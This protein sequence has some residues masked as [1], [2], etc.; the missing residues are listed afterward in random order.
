MNKLRNMTYRL[1][2]LVLFFSGLLLRYAGF[3]EPFQ[4]H[5]DERLIAIWM[6]RMHETYSLLPKVYAGGFFVLANATRKICEGFVTQI[7]HRWAYFV[8]DT[9]QFFP[10]N[11]DPFDF[12]RQFNAWLG[13]GIILICAAWTL[14]VTRSRA[15]ALT[16]AALMAFAAFPI[17]HSHYL[18]S[19]IAMLATLAMALLLM[20][21]ALAT[22]RLFDFSLAAFATGFAI[23][24]KFPLISL[25]AP[26]L[27]SIRPPLHSTRPR[28]K[29]AW[30]VGLL[31]LALVLIT[32][33]VA[34]ACPDL[35]HFSDF[36]AGLKSGGSS[37]YAETT[38]ILGPAASEPHAR[39][40]MNASNLLRF[41]K[42]LQPGWLAVAALGIPLCFTRPLRLYW[43]VTLLFPALFLWY[44]IFK[45]PWSRSQ[46]FMT[47]L[48]NFCLWAALPVAALWHSPPSTFKKSLAL[49]L[50]CIAVLPTL[51][52]GVSMSS[53]FAWEDTRRLANRTLTTCFPP[54]SPLGIE[55]YTDPAEKHVSTRALFIGEYESANP[56]FFRS[57]QVEYVLIHPDTHGR[58]V[59][60]PRTGK[61]FPGYA[62]RLNDLHQQGELL[63][64]WGP[65]SS[66]APQ[67][68]F[69]AP[70]LELW[71]L[72]LENPHP[73]EELGVELPRPT[74]VQEEG[75]TTFFRH[76]LRAGP[77]I[78]VLV[79]KF[80]REIA[81]G[82]PGSLEGTLFLVAS[83]Q[84]RATT[85]RATGFG[86]TQRAV[87]G[88][89]DA[90]AI[91]M[92]RP[93]WNPR[94]VRYE[95]IVVQTEPRIPTL[96]YLPCFLRVA[97]SP[98]EAATLLLDEGHPQKAVALLRQYN[99][100]E[101]AG[102]FW[103][104]LA[105]DPNA[106]TEAEN[107]LARW[108][109]WLSQEDPLPPLRIAGISLSAWQD[110]AR[111]RLT[112][113]H[114]PSSLHLFPPPEIHLDHRTRALTQLLPVL[115]ANQTLSMEL[116][117]YPDSFE[118]TYS[119]NP[120]FL[121]IA[122]SLTLDT[123]EFSELPILSQSPRSSSYSST[124]FPRHIHVTFRS[125]FEATLLA[126]QA[127]FTWNW[128]DML[129]LRIQQL[130]RALESPPLRLPS[131]RYGD[132][133]ALRDCHL[134]G[135]QISLTF[136]ALQ[137]SIPPLAAQVHVI[138]NAKWRSRSTASLSTPGSVWNTGERRTIQLPM[139]SDF[140]P[141]R[142]GI[143]I[144]TD[145]P[146]HASILPMEGAPKN[147]P[148]PLLDAL[149]LDDHLS[150]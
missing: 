117:R 4:L 72:P 97:F 37:V 19:D 43:P 9:N 20:A 123:I 134:D 26:L 13:A 111:I 31:L 107:L 34:T 38:G 52:T 86:K 39:E 83:T 106:K 116:S 53:Q 148:F 50:F 12:G 145:V 132:W 33:G 119:N 25:L 48:P 54:Q 41:A 149:L 6:N 96:T 46:E 57:N 143:A 126:D 93:S 98:L 118:R 58:G 71:R 74:L 28:Q 18:E 147:R 109:Q 120:I 125:H 90:A 69:R 62:K 10:T 102:P 92:Q 144:L 36:I 113:L 131:V 60:D 27:A 2:L 121:D 51:H 146:Y 88:P 7:T 141:D 49:L 64:T 128:R 75:R 63:A 105:G 114:E 30:I 108:F 77:R 47:F 122:N 55:L 87:L 59:Y 91:P 79:D 65:L 94:W 29:A 21:R 22:R 40:W 80:P 103:R 124:T 101:T 11:L 66:P 110:F 70:H 8:R 129:S 140:S 85:V 139:E 150:W 135:N 95:R 81:I 5:P 44:I 16:A 99:E 1:S 3:T 130:R 14:R 17:E 84:E 42:S 32:A 112:S 68:T 137:D 142:I 15:G 24:T 136:E 56:H 45:A 89:Y 23:G 67:P 82:G 138:K 100:L 104:A 127:T 35:F 76:E 133:I 73:L 61:P 78:A 115:N